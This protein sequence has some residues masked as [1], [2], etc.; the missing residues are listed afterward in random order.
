MPQEFDSRRT[1]WV[2]TQDSRDWR[3]IRAIQLSHE[4]STAPIDQV[5]NVTEWTILTRWER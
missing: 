3:P 2:P 5:A 1:Q 4:I